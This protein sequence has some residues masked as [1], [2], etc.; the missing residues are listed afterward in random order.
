MKLKTVMR[1]L[2][3]GVREP[4]SWYRRQL[5][6]QFTQL[7]HIFQKW[8]VFVPKPANCEIGRSYEIRKLFHPRSEVCNNNLLLSQNLH[9]GVTFFLGLHYS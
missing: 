9:G 7:L 4:S 5:F 8:I 2:F 3:E 1:Y 6:A